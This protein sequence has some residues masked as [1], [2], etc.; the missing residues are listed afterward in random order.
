MASPLMIIVEKFP[1]KIR[2]DSVNLEQHDKKEEYQKIPGWT[3]AQR[4]EIL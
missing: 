3:L 2:K 4:R 1:P